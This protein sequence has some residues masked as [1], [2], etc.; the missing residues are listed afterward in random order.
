MAIGKLVKVPIAILC[1][2]MHA[3]SQ[4]LSNDPTRQEEAETQRQDARRLRA[5]IP[6]GSGDLDDE[7]DEAFERLVKMDHR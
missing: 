6:G 5:Q 4:A 2:C 7:S 3:F 1:R